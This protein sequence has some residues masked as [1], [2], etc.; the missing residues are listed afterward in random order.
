MQFAGLGLVDPPLGPA[1]VE[2]DGQ[3]AFAVLAALP[4]EVGIALVELR[5]NW[6]NPPGA[7]EATK[8]PSPVVEIS[9]PP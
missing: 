6:L 4:G 7:D 3:V 8:K 9:S 2:V 1:I 5:D